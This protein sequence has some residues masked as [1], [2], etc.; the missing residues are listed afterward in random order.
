MLEDPMWRVK[1]RWRAEVWKLRPR[2][3]STADVPFVSAESPFDVDTSALTRVA[4]ASAAAAIRAR[5][6]PLP[7][8]EPAAPGEG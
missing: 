5:Y 6:G 8:D 1:E 7:A 2:L 4:G 3:V